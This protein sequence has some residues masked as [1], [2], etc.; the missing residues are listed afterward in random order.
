VRIVISTSFPSN[1]FPHKQLDLLAPV[2]WYRGGVR[3][4]AIDR[5]DV[6]PFIAFGVDPCPILCTQN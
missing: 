6:F 3:D 5:Q 2:R 1:P 4:E